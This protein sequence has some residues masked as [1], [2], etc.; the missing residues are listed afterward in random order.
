MDDRRKTPRVKLECPVLMRAL[1]KPETLSLTNSFCENI[2]ELGLK[3][4][5]FNYYLM[6]EKVHLHLF[7]PDC[8]NLLDAVGEVVWVEKL[9]FQS[10]YKV[11]IRFVEES[12]SFYLKV[13]HLIKNC[14]MS[15]ILKMEGK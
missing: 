13:K 10:R 8:A 9:P 11:G 12:K 2:S 1:A 6:K 5:S 14:I 4:T 3:V 7:S 15:L